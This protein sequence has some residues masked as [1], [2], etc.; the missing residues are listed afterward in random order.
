[1]RT[2]ELEI[3]RNSYIVS[4]IL[5][6]VDVCLTTQADVGAKQQIQLA[7]A[8]KIFKI[9]LDNNEKLHKKKPPRSYAP[10]KVCV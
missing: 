6:F 4:T 2:D 1:M 10:P 7:L 9:G 5:A 8:S 3:N